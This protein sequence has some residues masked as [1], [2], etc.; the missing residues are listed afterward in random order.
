MSALTASSSLPPPPPA[1]VADFLA[2]IA[3]GERPSQVDLS[4]CGL[5]EIPPEVF[6]LGD[7]VQLLN[8]GGNH[9]SD[10]PPAMTQLTNLRILF[11]ASN[12]FT[13]IPAVLGTMP[14]L[15]MLSF[16]SNQ[17]ETVPAD[18]LSPTVG[19]LI[20]TD[21]RIT[22]LPSSIGN[23][24]HLRKCMLAGNR[25]THLPDAMAQCRDLELLRIA[26]NDL[27]VA[28][29]PTWLWRLPKLSWLALAGNDD[30]GGRG[31]AVAVAGE[32]AAGIPSVAWTD[33]DVREKLGEG[34][35]GVIY[36]AA[37]RGGDASSS[38]ASS[39]ASGEGLHQE[40]AVKLFK[41]GKT[42]DGLP[43]DEMKAAQAAGDHPC[44]FRVLAK[45]AGAPD[46]QAGLVF[47]LIPPEY[48]VL[49]GPPS[50]DS[51]TRDTFPA[52]TRFTPRFVLRTLRGVAAV[53]THL[54][55]RGISHGDLYAH[56]ILVNAEGDPLLSDFGAATFYP[57][58]RPP[59]GADEGSSS[60]GGAGQ[61]ET[62]AA[63]AMRVAMEGYEVRA[64]GC[65]VE[66]LLAH[67]HTDDADAD[68]AGT[69]CAASSN[70]NSNSS[71]SGGGGGKV[72]GALEA[73]RSLQ[74]A[75]T[76]PDCAARPRF[77]DIAARLAAI[78]L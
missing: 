34:A 10:L 54:H 37:W 30:A 11:F 15:Y 64:F 78:D 48:T 32:A 21:N 3:R 60:S 4:N 43:E 65:L 29:L 33:L 71:T 61:G 56:N 28:E 8:L 77:H 67:T 39:S 26:A 55:A 47:P 17:I 53:C 63:A 27:H 51:V 44:S 73:L 68:A 22:E 69:T 72:A 13:T 59:G 16:K 1:K 24:V 76:V 57:A 38:F 12:N 36:K 6:A 49:G 45:V 62:P 41:G 19:W 58:A 18:A 66:D 42:S 7:A 2:A 35:S 74:A 52:G 31:A 9:L 40:V 20:L 70:S 23:L 75:C 50:F 14:S 46:G 25:L 5:T